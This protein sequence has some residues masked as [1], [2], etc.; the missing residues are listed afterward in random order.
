MLDVK[1]RDMKKVGKQNVKHKPAIKREDLRYLKESEVICPTTPQGLLYNECF[2]V[3]PY[4]C[5]W[6][7]EGQRNLT[8]SCF[9]FLQY[10]NNK[11]YATMAHEESSKTRQERSMTPYHHKLRE[12]W[13]NVP[14]RSLEWWI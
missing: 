11:W 5:R 4:F 12:T 14:D 1:L 9:L 10:K 7:R 3:T 6:G 2:H 8:K 13:K